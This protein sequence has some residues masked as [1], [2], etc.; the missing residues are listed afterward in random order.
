[1]KKANKYLLLWIICIVFLTG[2]WDRRELD[3]LGIVFG[4]GLD[5]DEQTGDIIFTKQIVRPGQTGKDGGGEKGTTKLIEARG[6][7]IFEAIRNATKKSDR[8]GYY[9]HTKLIIINEE[10]AKEGIAY[11]LDF[12]N[13]SHEV[14]SLV[15]IIITKD[16]TARE[17]LSIEGGIE[18][19]Q[20]SYLENMIKNRGNTSQEYVSNILE[21]NKKF[22]AEGIEPV[23]GRM[24]V[25]E[26][27][28]TIEEK[29]EE[30][31]NQEI[32]LSGT[33]VFHKD[34]LVGYLNELETRGFNWMV[35]E[36]DSGVLLVKDPKNQ[37]EMITIE[38]KEASSK[39]VPKIIGG[40]ILFEIQV[41][42]QGNIVEQKGKAD[43]SDLKVFE[44]IEEEQKKII[45]MEIERAMEKIQKDLKSDIVGFGQHLYRK[46]PKEW[47]NIKDEWETIFPKVKY[48]IQIETKLERT[49]L[50]LKTMEEK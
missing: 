5:K 38:I 8:E 26:Q 44:Q 40:K 15:W 23:A 31:M 7:T 37:E 20:A 9:A 47:E 12:A 49:G 41:K 14:R 11:I 18:D 33:A 32:V 39:I 10:V 28:K 35:G 13:R 48:T 46:Y 21:F 1:M 22:S 25:V 43:V 36:V 3:E 16:V 27:D 2:C 17:I 24:K 50:M 4:I 6:N 19:I 29:K 34:K 45:Q 42:E 30:N